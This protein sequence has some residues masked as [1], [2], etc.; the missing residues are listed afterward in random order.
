MRQKIALDEALLHEIRDEARKELDRNYQQQLKN[1][2]TKL[3]QE[4]EARLTK[5]IQLAETRASERASKRLEGQL[6]ILRTE[7]EEERKYNRELHKK[8][9]ELTRQLQDARKAQETA[10]LNM[11]RKLLEEEKK[12]RANA[13]KTATEKARLELAE[14]DKTINDLKKALEDA[15]RKAAQGS[16]QLQGEVLELDLEDALRREFIYDEIQPVEKGVSGADVK[17]IVKTQ[18]G[19]TCGVIL[20][21]IKRTKNWSDAWIQKLKADMRAEGAHCPAIITEVMPKEAHSNIYQHRGVWV[22]KPAMAIVLA[23]LL[24]EGLL[25]AARERAIAKHRE[26][27][28]EALYNFITGHEFAHHVEA[29]LETYRSMREQI[30]R[31]RKAYERLWK[32]REAQLETLTTGIA[33]VYGSL[34]GRV[35]YASMPKVKGL[36]LLEAGEDLEEK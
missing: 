28:A 9:Q 3:N 2:E 8:L 22:C 14:R 32:Q 18:R 34:E 12:I 26:T 11:Q 4:A 7:A 35:G 13:E 29:M 19:V 10:E 17:Q 21:E 27:A 5:Q 36:E 31:E 30:N 1:L 6:Q 15:Q 33:A 20:W 24:R 16:Q 23:K 25:A